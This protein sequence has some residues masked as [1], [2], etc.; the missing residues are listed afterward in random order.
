MEPRVPKRLP[1]WIPKVTLLGTSGKS[2]FA[3]I[4]NVFSTFEG[5]RMAPGPKSVPFGRHSQSLFFEAP[6]L[7][8]TTKGSFE[9]IL[10]LPLGPLFGL[11]LVFFWGPDISC[12]LGSIFGRGLAAGA[13]PTEAQESAELDSLSNTP[14]SPCGG[15]ANLSGCAHA[16]DP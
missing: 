9:A 13:R 5:P 11:I 15:A 7:K 10:C 14:G 3:A 12:I 4:Y 16:A 1:K 2:I 6:G 8:K